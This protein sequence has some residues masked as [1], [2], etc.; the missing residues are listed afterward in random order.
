VSEL[1]VVAGTWREVK[2][3]VVSRRTGLDADD[4]SDPVIQAVH[5]RCSLC[6]GGLPVSGKASPHSFRGR[7]SALEE[8]ALREGERRGIIQTAALHSGAFLPE[9]Y[10]CIMDLV[11]GNV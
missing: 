5:E 10:I 8:P 4:S 9:I 11:E 2:G 1:R 6:Y 7:R 3:K